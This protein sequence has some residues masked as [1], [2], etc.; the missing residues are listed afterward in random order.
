MYV[1]QEKGMISIFQIIREGIEKKWLL[2]L[3]LAGRPSLGQAG[4]KIK[5]RLQFE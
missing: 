4:T 2:K 1:L 5:H 3:D